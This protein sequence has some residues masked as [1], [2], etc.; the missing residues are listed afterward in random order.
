MTP[1]DYLDLEATHAVDARAAHREVDRLHD[2]AA[3]KLK[4]DAN[5]ASRNLNREESGTE[6]WLCRRCGQGVKVT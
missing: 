6:V 2:V 5:K 4:S 3:A 1:P